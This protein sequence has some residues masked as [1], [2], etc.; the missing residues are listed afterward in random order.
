[1]D[2]AVATGH[3]CFFI[4]GG[5]LTKKKTPFLLHCFGEE[6]FIFQLT[7]AQA[8]ARGVQR[9]TMCSGRNRCAIIGSLPKPIISINRFELKDAAI[10]QS[11]P[12]IGR[13]HYHLERDNTGPFCVRLDYAVNSGNRVAWDY[14]QRPLW[15]K[16]MLD[17]AFMPIAPEAELV[18]NFKGP[19]VLF[20]RLLEMSPPEQTNSRLPISNTG[21]ALVDVL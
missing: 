12:I 10:T 14:P 2:E 15:G 16:G 18:A 17:V 4:L 7:D 9:D 3:D 6:M 11:Q 5:K 13:I 1:M 19:L 8:A 20:V 21:A